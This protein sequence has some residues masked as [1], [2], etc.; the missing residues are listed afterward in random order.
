MNDLDDIENQLRAIM[1]WLNDVNT[2]LVRD[3]DGL[4]SKRLNYAYSD[5]SLAA[6]AVGIRSGEI[7]RKI[8]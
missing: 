5:V 8:S 1:T 3:H 2:R 4:G 7:K 6:Q